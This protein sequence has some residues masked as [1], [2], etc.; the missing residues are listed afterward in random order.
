MQVIFG[1]T[2]I[3][4]QCACDL[5]PIYTQSVKFPLLIEQLFSHLAIGQVNSEISIRFHSV[6]IQGVHSLKKTCSN[7]RSQT[8]LC[9]RSIKVDQCM[10][11]KFK[12]NL[13][14]F[15]FL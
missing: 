12:S 4:L 14:E 2:V 6:E 9:E 15:F 11:S 13:K 3:W 7:A 5:L 1:D 8:S 10:N